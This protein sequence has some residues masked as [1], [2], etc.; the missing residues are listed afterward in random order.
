MG[1]YW[2][3]EVR[4]RLDLNQMADH[5]RF[6]LSTTQ[7][8]TANSTDQK[9]ASPSQPPDKEQ[10]TGDELLVKLSSVMGILLL[11]LLL[12]DYVSALSTGGE[13]CLMPEIHPGSI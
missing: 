6:V 1:C 5:I 4:K 11:K 2:H 12:K 7:I 10:K 3:R 9:D 8:M 13:S